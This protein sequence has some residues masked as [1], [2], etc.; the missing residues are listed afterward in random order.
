MHTCGK[1]DENG[2]HLA[3]DKTTCARCGRSWCERCD[4]S[5]GPL[6]HYCHGR[7]W[8]K[9]PLGP[10]RCYKVRG[11]CQDETGE[12]NLLG[13]AVV[14]AASEAEAEKQA[15]DSL[16]DARLTAADCYWRATVCLICEYCW[17]NEPDGSCEHCGALVCDGCHMDGACCDGTDEDGCRVYGLLPDEL[18]E[19]QPPFPADASLWY[20]HVTGRPAFI[21]DGDYLGIVSEDHAKRIAADVASEADLSRISVAK[22]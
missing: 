1:T 22:L 11:F 3:P 16:W 12:R 10:L 15:R 14:H 17:E 8:S 13:A 5:P 21:L 6:C 4:P 9:A 19:I 18:D 20:V 7:G 2:R